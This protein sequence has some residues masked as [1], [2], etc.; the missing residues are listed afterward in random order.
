MNKI[1][2][3]VLASILTVAFFTACKSKTETDPKATAEA[4]YEALSKKDFDVA[5][6]YA[7]QE[8]QSALDMMK[9]AVKMA[10]QFGKKDDIDFAK[11]LKGKTISYS[12]PEMDGP[13]Q[14]R[15]TILADGKEQMP[16]ILKK[17]NE[18][19]K[20]AF[21]KATIMSSERDQMNEN[22]AR[23]SNLTDTIIDKL[24]NV[25]DS[26]RNELEESEKKLDSLKKAIP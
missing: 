21:D 20:V 16:L 18:V 15:V 13:N 25:H 8:S 1:F 7:T 17:E 22:P 14:A 6:K 12:E 11:E 10:E 4:F 2:Y 26:V 9:S 24:E 3:T 19:W 5:A 23:D